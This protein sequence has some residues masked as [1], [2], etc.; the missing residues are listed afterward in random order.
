[1]PRAYDR[2]KETSTT[3]G[4]GAITLSGTA[5]TGYQTFANRFALNELFMYCIQ[6]SASGLWEVGEGYLSASTTLVRDTVTDGSS[7]F[8]TLVNFTAGTKDVF[9]TVAAHFFMDVAGGAILHK[10]N[11]LAMP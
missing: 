6:D 10:I 11:G 3:T 1:M 8:G 7:G 5:P 9:C 4:T 2:I